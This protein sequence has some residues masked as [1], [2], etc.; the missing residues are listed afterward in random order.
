VLAVA[1]PLMRSLA[2]RERLNVGLAAPGRDK[3]MCHESIGYS[4]R[5]AFRKVT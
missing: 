5:F 1:A 4:R 3:M 2:E